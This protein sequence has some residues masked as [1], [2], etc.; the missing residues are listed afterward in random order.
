[1]AADLLERP[2]VAVPKQLLDAVVAWC[3]PQ[4]VIL[5]GSRARGDHRPDSDWDLLAIVER[6]ALERPARPA[7][8]WPRPTHI[9]LK[10]RAKFEAERDLA[11]TT[12]N[13]ADEDGVVVWRRPGWRP[14]PRR[15]RSVTAEQR[16]QVAERWLTRSERDLKM[17]RLAIEAGDELLDNAAFHLQ[18]A[19][20]KT[21]K[22]ILA[23]D[24]SRFRKIHKLGELAGWVLERHPEL[25]AHVEGLDP[26]T[27]W[28]GA[29]RYDDTDAE[30]PITAET[31]TNLLHRC[32]T[33]LAHARGLAPSAEQPR[34]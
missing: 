20:E 18:Q 24:G 9:F 10:A 3:E 22:A 1:M 21:L 6:E 30:V 27:S 23:A 17:A 32:E 12:A 28:V 13:A 4:E 33:L 5:F 34:D 2:R 8:R 31:V 7:P 11:G 16:W 14:S 25:A 19:A 29:G 26:Y 15:R